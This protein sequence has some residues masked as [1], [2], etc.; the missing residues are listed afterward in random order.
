MPPEIVR[1]TEYRGKPID[2]WSFGVVA[3]ACLA[4][5][6]PFAARS[7]SDLYRKILRGT[8][9]LPEG[10]SHG[11]GSLL[12]AAIHVD[13]QRRITAPEARRHPW[14]VD[15][16]AAVEKACTDP[17]PLTR[18][19]NYNDD[20]HTDSMNHMDSIGVPRDTLIRALAQADHS[21][22]T[23]CYY[24]H[25]GKHRGRDH[26]YSASSSSSALSDHHYKF[27]S[28]TP[29]TTTSSHSGGGPGATG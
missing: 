22:I 25:L 10:Q 19:P 26:S 27:T 11:A 23:A 20:V 15:G 3:Y 24:L 1:R 29:R 17:G 12:Q 14:L 5:Y 13:V 21:P 9:R 16:N 28:T 2:L 6:F 7:Q 8:F 4:G 18:A